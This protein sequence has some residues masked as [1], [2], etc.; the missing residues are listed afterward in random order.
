MTAP[1]RLSVRSWRPA[2][3]CG[4]LLSSERPSSRPPASVGSER[5]LALAAPRRLE[6]AH[7]PSIVAPTALP[8]EHPTDRRRPRYGPAST[9]SAWIR[10]GSGPAP[11]F[12]AFA[13]IGRRRGSSAR[14]PRRSPRGAPSS[15]SGRAPT[16]PSAGGARGAMARCCGTSRRRIRLAIS[17]GCAR[18]SARRSSTTSAS[19]RARCWGRP[20]RTCSRGRC[21]RSCWT[22]TSIP[23]RGH[24]RGGWTPRCSCT[25]TRPQARPR[26]R[27]RTAAGGPAGRD[28]RS[29]PAA[30]APRAPSSRRVRAHPQPFRGDV[31]DPPALLSSFAGILYTTQ[32]EPGGFSG[33]MASRRSCRRSGSGPTPSRGP[34]LPCSGAIRGPSSRPPSSARTARA[35]V[36][37]PPIRASRGSRSGAPA[38]SA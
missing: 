9:W 6:V 34:S 8:K 7:L 32:P 29:R 10:A 15:A 5:L 13:P 19:H 27:S 37:P 24:G 36:G 4:D 14:P 17:T 31:V 28:A 30:P 11:R 12:S 26:P 18:P 22:A 2:S 20:T 23:S 16:G 33:W 35:R 25:P 1:F 3:R 21:A 38:S